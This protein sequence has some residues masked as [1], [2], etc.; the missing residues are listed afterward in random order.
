MFNNLLRYSWGWTV[1]VDVFSHL[2]I[3]KNA[4]K[5]D[6]WAIYR[7]EAKQYRQRQHYIAKIFVSWC[8]CYIS[9]EICGTC[10]PYVD[11]HELIGQN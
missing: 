10:T 8:V 9:I 3:T 11:S 1:A 2:K 4:K 6:S 5:A 7:E